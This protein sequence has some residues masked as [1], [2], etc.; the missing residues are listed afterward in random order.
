MTT[1]NGPATTTGTESTT[2]V[3]RTIDE[4]PETRPDPPLGDRLA[5]ARERVGRVDLNVRLAW[6]GAGLTVLAFLVLPYAGSRGPGVEV[7]GRLWWRPLLA[8]AAA[9]LVHMLARRAYDGD[10]RTAIAAVAVASA[11]VTEAGLFGLVSSSSANLRVG[12]FLML[13]GTVVVLVAALRAATRR[14]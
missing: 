9:A 4:R 2:A 11:A 13:L 12:F 6:I 7:G 3:L 5:E 8:I 1:T 10:N 14:A